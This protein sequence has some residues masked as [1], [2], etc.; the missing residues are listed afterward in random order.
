VR[1]LSVNIYDAWIH[2]TLSRAIDINTSPIRVSEVLNAFF[3]LFRGYKVGLFVGVGEL[4]S[5]LIRR[6]RVIF[7]P[8]T[9][10]PTYTNIFQNSKKI[11]WMPYFFSK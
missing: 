2:E 11:K 10:T 9:S 4:W 1:N 6:L 8:T 3:I 7:P 5:G